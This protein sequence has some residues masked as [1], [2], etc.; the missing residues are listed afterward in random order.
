MLTGERPM[1]KNTV[2]VALRRMEIT[3]DEGEVPA[4]SL[5]TDTAPTTQVSAA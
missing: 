2:N 4:Q 3:V 5:D 1:S